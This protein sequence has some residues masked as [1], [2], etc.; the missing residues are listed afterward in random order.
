MNKQLKADFMLLIVVISWG[1]SFLLTDI[2]TQSLD[3]FNLNA[4]RFLVAFFVAI[5]FTFPKLRNI[6]KETLKWSVLLGCILAV[7]YACM[8]I[9]V[10][11][12]TLSNS[13]FLCQLT[14]IVTPILS[15][16][17]NKK[18]P[19]KKVLFVAIISLIGIALL[20]L[21]DGFTLN[22]E[23]LKGDIF[24]LICGI[25][26]AVHLVTTERALSH[27]N[28][29]AFQIGVLQLG[30][31]GVISLFF[32]LITENPHLPYTPKVWISTLFL[33]IFCTGLAF[34]IQTLAQQYT[35]ASHVGVIFSLEPVIAGFVAYFFAGDIL[36][37]RAYF[38]AF[39]M[40]LSIFIMEIDFSFLR[41]R[42]SDE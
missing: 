28:T 34:L 16:I 23:N 3:P 18:S 35:S 22:R 33:A 29:S 32:S 39:L 7:M 38:G 30:T 17:V 4:V 31:T 1:F 41:R 25:V 27:E 19:E 15:G 8:N 5:I 2:S 20:T 10:K 13:G 21:N 37:L 42:I 40:V 6:S 9:G 11:N 14:V 36:T 24:C 12:T 26:Y